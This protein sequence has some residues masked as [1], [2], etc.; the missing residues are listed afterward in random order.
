MDLVLWIVGAPGWQTEKLIAKI[1]N[2]EEYGKRL[3]W[4]EKTKDTDLI[5]LYK[6][7]DYLIAASYGE[8]YG[9]PLAEAS[10]YNLTV[11]A[12]DI[13]VFREISDENT[14]FF[15]ATPE[16]NLLQIIQNLPKPTNFQRRQGKTSR[17]VSWNESFIDF[18]EKVSILSKSSGSE[19]ND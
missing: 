12:R 6:S 18:V 1:R 16:E 11:I 13:P 10:L 8:G 9:L 17:R 7:A 5:S 2:H 19:S 14:V 4:H 3:F 15:N